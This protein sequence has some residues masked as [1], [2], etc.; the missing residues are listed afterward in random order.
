MNT[1]NWKKVNLH[2]LNKFL[3]THKVSVEELDYEIS[4]NKLIRKKYKKKYYKEPI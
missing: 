2:E 4:Q 1:T 3:K